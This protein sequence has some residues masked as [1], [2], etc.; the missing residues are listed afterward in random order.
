M[1]AAVD[2]ITAGIP[3]S[4]SYREGVSMWVW[5]DAGRF[6]FPRIGVEAVGATWTTSFRIAFCLAHPGGRLHLVTDDHPP[7]P[8]AD[9]RG[10]PRVLG[11]GPL[12]FECIEPFRHWR[13][14]FDGSVVSLEADE[15]L[16]GG[17]ARVGLDS[18]QDT[19]PVQLRLDALAEV[20]PWF[21]GSH[22]PEGHAVAG[23][24]RFEQLCSVTG[25]VDLGG[26]VT[27][28]TGGAL[29]VHRKGGDRND[30]G[31]F[32]GHNWQSAR[33][34]SGRAFGFIHYRPQPDGTPT[35]R[36]G[37]LLDGGEVV[38]AQ[39]QGTPWMTD[40]RSSGEDVSFTLR[41][42]TD[43]VHIG[44]TTFVSSLRPPRAVGDGIFFPLLQSGIA[45]YRWDD[46]EAY[47]MVERSARLGEE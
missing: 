21:Q 5:D 28:F 41:T 33:F 27:P 40:T 37:W 38:P 25:E 19:V 3:A 17:V 16:R 26:A 8:V 11:A 32:P 34:P 42:A 15:H 45:R 29:R 31:S 44:G 6:G 47:G 10:R 9:E 1:D 24:H 4:P 39:V 20:P 36:E 35:Y 23:E 14:T 22:D 13:L 12:R 7:L 30:Y 46:E 43:E 2:E 18:A